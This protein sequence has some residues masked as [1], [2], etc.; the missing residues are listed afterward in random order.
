M[1]NIIQIDLNKILVGTPF[2]NERVIGVALSGGRDSIALCHA[3]KAAGE[4]IVAIN[5]GHGIRGE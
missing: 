2:E 1:A 4:K 3:L 5:V